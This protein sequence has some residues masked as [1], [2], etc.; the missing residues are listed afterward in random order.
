M[1]SL[2]GLIANLGR[3][4]ARFLA[5]L[6]YAGALSALERL[7]SKAAEHGAR[8]GAGEKEMEEARMKCFTT[9]ARS[10][11]QVSCRGCCCEERLP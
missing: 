11:P 8:T 3:I 4:S 2:Y 10:V 6:V 1:A 5:R 9:F 7:G